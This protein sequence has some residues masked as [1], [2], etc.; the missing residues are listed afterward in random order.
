MT[1]SR[2]EKVRRQSRGATLRF[3]VYR[4][5]SFCQPLSLALTQ[6]HFLVEKNKGPKG[7]DLMEL[8]Q[9]VGLLGDVLCI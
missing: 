5:L 7:I 2:K 1:D 9:R 3:H 6:S 4:T 8:E